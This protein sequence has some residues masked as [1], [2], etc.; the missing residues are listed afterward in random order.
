MI[1]QNFDYKPYFERAPLALLDNLA[2]FVRNGGALV[3]VGGDRSFDLGEY[4][5]TPIED[6]LPVK[7]GLTANKADESGFRPAL[8]TAGAQHPVTRLA[9][10]PKDNEEAW[11]RLP[12]LDG[13]NRSMGL[14]PKAA[15]LLG[16]PSLKTNGEPLP[17]LAVREV[18][19]GRTMAL[20]VDASWRWSFSE[21]AT[22]RGNQ[23]Y[24]RFWKGALR[25]LVA[26][27]DERRVVVRPSTEAFCSVRNF[28]WPP[29][30]AMQ[31][32][33]GR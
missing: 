4:G 29:W 31:D 25:W 23:A 20:T 27:P 7:L 22:G 3:M 30:F 6:V 24:L 16:H 26:D 15:M 2:R 18:G 14:A 17:V 12:S 1:L 8:T 10:N 28:G 33:V 19:R 11:A 13:L 9:G 21:A 32:T 5:G